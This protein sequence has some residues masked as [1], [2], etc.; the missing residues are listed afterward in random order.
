MEGTAMHATILNAGIFGETVLTYSRFAKPQAADGN[1]EMIDFEQMLNEALVRGLPGKSGG[2]VDASWLDPA[3]LAAPDWAYRDARGECAGLV[4]GHRLG[5]GIGTLDNRHMLTVAGSRGGKGVSLIV[6]NLLLYDGSVIAIDPKGELAAITARARRAKGQTVVVLDPFGVSGLADRGSFNPLDELDAASGT[7]KDDAGIIADAL[8][9]GSEREP[10]FT[11]TA[12]I[13]VKTLI[14]YVL[15]FDDPGERT[16]VSVFKL[17]NGSHQLILDV[18]ERSEGRVT[19]RK[20]LFAL[21]R[22]CT[23]HYGN[24]VAG[25]GA[26]FADMAER[27]IA[28]VLST[29]LTQLE[30]LESEDMERVLQSS[31]MRLSDLKTE[32][33]TVYLCLPAMRMGTH[34]RWLRVLINLALVAMERTRSTSSVPVLTILDEFP[35][36]GHMKSVETAAGLMAGFG[37]KLWV[38]VQD[39]TQLRRLYEHSWETFIGNAGV[40]TFWSNTDKFT[41]E[42]VSERLGQTAVRLQHRNEV[43]PQQRLGGASGMRDE[44]RVQRLAAA[45]ELEKI[46]ERRTDRILVMA[47]GQSPVILQRFHYYRDAPFKSLFDT[48]RG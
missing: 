2:I 44:L 31:R 32:R 4:L 27:E 42:H 41:L 18:T 34:A 24:A 13:L 40:A 38:V 48:W 7:V 11:D 21:L 3:L 5:R 28:S 29:A 8:I 46:L 25:M 47:A 36:L 45:N 6:P 33:A 37:V 23:G 17:L 15:T 39:L 16:L 26:H 20:A 12:R 1:Y 19:G 14:L 43:T 10:H 9:V 22:A 30:F 35:V